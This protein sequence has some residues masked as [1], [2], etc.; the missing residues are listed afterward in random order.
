[1]K[2]IA[3][4]LAVFIVVLSGCVQTE[5][6][7]GRTM[8]FASL[9][10]IAQAQ[11]DE[12]VRMRRHFHQHP[13]L[14]WLEEKTLDYIVQAVNGYEGA[15]R[16]G[17]KFKIV[18]SIH[19]GIWVDIDV[20]P[21]LDRQIFRADVDALPVPEA[22]GLEFASL[23]TGISHACGHDCHAAMLL[24]FFKAVCEN[25]IELKHNLRLVFQRAEENPGSEPQALSGG[26]VMVQEKVCRGISRAYALHVWATGDAGVFYSRPG[27]FLGNSDRLKLVISCSGG[28]VAQPHKG[29]NALRIA[30]QI[31]NSLES[32]PAQVLGPME[33][34]SLEPTI[35]KAGTASNIMPATAEL[36]FGV[37]TMLEPANR[38]K[39]FE[40]LASK[41]SS[42]VSSFP[43]AT[44]EFKPIH[45]HPALI[46][47]GSTVTLVS[48][49]LKSAGELYKEHER[50]LGAEDF[51]YY[52]QRVPG[53]QV[54]LGANQQGC[55][56]HHTP[57]FNPDEAV[58]WKGVY[59]WLLLATN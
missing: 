7:V 13:E 14:R 4:V 11:Q 33:P 31:T 44:V 46:N 24:G 34:C 20:D 38:D 50:I 35:L 40:H 12:V 55:G 51:A 47:A 52:L 6:K 1:M 16:G 25:K 42:V 8:D 58:L 32:F 23:E 19:G 26:Q 5:R 45:G 53:C 49:T 54:M 57:T 2:K 18:V 59:F 15:Y 22:T 48:A 9:R 29:Q 10:A 28:H 37:R 27:P 3:A 39:F 56:D 43:G 17:L 21:K 30:Q 36:W 41:V